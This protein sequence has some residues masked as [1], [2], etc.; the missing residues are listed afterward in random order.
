MFPGP[1][2][3]DDQQQQ[4]HGLG[5]A[6]DGGKESLPKKRW[7]WREFHGISTSFGQFAGVSYL[8]GNTLWIFME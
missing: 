7:V 4:N 2:T 3:V 8:D 5:E 6:T 1:G